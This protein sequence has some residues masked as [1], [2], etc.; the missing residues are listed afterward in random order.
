MVRTTRV[1]FF[2][3]QGFVYSDY[4]VIPFDMENVIVCSVKESRVNDDYEDLRGEG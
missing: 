3:E 1:F 2:E 4:A